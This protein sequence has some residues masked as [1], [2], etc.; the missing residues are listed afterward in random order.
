VTIG[1]VYLHL[2]SSL[3]DATR[4]ATMALPAA[5]LPRGL[6]MLRRRGWAL[7]APLSILVVAAA[8]ELSSA[9]ADALAWIA[10]LLVPPGC[11][12]ALGWA[13]RGARPWLAVAALPLLAA[14][15]TVPDDTVGELAR[16][17]L[18]GGSCITV[19]RLL[20]GAAPL[21]LVKAGVIAM[22]T[23]DS[24]IIFGH[25]FDQQNAVFE[26]AIASPGLPQLQT[27]QLGTAGCDYGDF[28]AAGLAG[29]VVAAEGR[30]QL[31]AAAA[32]WL[33]SQVFNQLFLVTDIL[34]MT[35][36]PAIVV[37]ALWLI[38]ARGRAVRQGLQASMG[39]AA[40]GRSAGRGSPAGR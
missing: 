8:I 7:V 18:I 27:T 12:L 39:W 31:A 6:G 34:A 19:G 38:P 40:P 24:V 5:G 14:A 23:V 21:T 28:F 22:A 1:R 20:A 35:V 36:P 13:A 17:A 10:L 11:A 4:A 15:L 32:M 29:A 2:D 16:I 9:N 30:P 26:A 3:L 33:V 25:L 37:I